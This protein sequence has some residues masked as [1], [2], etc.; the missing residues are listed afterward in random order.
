MQRCNQNS[1][2]AAIAAMRHWKQTTIRNRTMILA[3]CGSENL[4]EL[5]A[6]PERSEH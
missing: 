3:Q 6:A 1:T 4:H 5:T 2:I